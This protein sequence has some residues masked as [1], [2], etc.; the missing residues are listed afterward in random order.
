MATPYI[1]E[2]IRYE[3]DEHP[4][5]AVALG[6]GFQA[7]MVILAPVA[8][9]V[10]I[11]A[12]IA[13]QS[14]DYISWGVFAVLV[15]SGLTTVL[16]AV[17]VGRFGSGHI[18]MMGTS[19]VFI[20]VCV[21][22][23]VVGGPSTMATLIVVSSLFQFALAARLSLM[24]RIFTP[25]VSGT[26]VMLIAATVMPLVFDSLTDVPEGTPPL[27]AP[28]A[29]LVA[30]VTVIALI[31][32]APAKWRLWAP[33]LGIAAG[34][35]V[36]LPFGLYDLQNVIAAPWI[37]LPQGTWPGISL[38]FDVK[39]WALLPAFVVATLVGAI[40]TMGDGVAIQR[41]SRR[42][43]GATDFRVIQGALNAVGLGHLLSGL[44]GALPNT[45]YSTSISLTEVTGIASRRVG[46][47]IGVV[48][49]VLAFFPKV[50]ALLIAIPSPVVSA[51]VTV[52]LGLLFVQGMKMV[53]Q[54]GAD[55]RKAAIV[56]LSFWVGVGF[57]NQSIFPELLGS[58]FLSILLGNG[59]TAGAIFAVVMMVFIELTGRRSKRMRVDLD[60]AALP[61]IDEFLRGLA[62]KSG[63]DTSAT[64]RLTAAAEETL[65]ILLQGD[66]SFPEGA[67]RRLVLA[68]R[69]EGHAAEM[70]FI[71][72]VEGEN[73]EDRLA[74]LGEMSPVPDEH[75]VS[76]R[77]LR[78]YSSSVRHQKYHGIDIIT[79]NVDA[80]R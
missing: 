22:A 43:P 4:P 30:L 24:R 74:Y 78:H 28:T 14:E 56:G 19:G 12:R 1:N 3:P 10:V 72:A 26:V 9:T 67:G 52:L 25:T 11:V 16:Q 20:A 44:A 79:V 77:L 51:Y 7:A 18:L 38:S 45:T 68:T 17:R 46:I 75:E 76:F 59:M 13:A 54:D 65:A 40:K 64:E 73:V 2:N 39:F 53:V 15:I 6:S 42:R 50:A 8:L 48:L 35:A 23:L 66:D 31:L 57:Q 61:Q 41:V 49:A 60:T 37:G 80:R 34:C 70:E 69:M 32:R 63:W 33:L 21:T 55:Y 47:V 58:G 5:T 71:S 29:A 36:S 27:A 62:A